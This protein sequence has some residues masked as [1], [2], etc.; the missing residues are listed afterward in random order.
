MLEQGYITE[1]EYEEASQVEIK[2]IVNPNIDALNTVSNYFADYTIQTVIN[3]LM[4]ENSYSYEE[5]S[6]LVYNGG[7]FK[8]IL[9][10]TLKH[11]KS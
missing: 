4:E 5:A 9:L 2:D 7:V 8:S 6:E 3:D 1:E 11:R 10:W